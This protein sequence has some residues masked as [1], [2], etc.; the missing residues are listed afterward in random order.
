MKQSFARNLKALADVFNFIDAFADAHRLDEPVRYALRLAVEELFTNA[1]KYNSGGQEG[2]ALEL[3]L[4]GEQ[5]V[6]QFADPDADRFDPTQQPEPPLRAPLEARQPGRLG[7]H[8]IKRY[9]DRVD[10]DYRGR[11]STITLTKQLGPPHV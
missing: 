6:V 7:I 8:L 5:L 3:S 11:M 4:A 10:Y 9:F 2:P 1:V